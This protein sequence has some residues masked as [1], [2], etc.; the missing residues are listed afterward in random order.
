QPGEGHPHPRWY[1]TFPRVLGHYVRD[2][3]LFT[4]EE[5]VRKVTSQAALRAGFADRGILRG[6]M[7]ADIVVFDDT[8]IRD[9]ATYEDPHHFSEGVST[10]IVNGV[11]V[12]RD[13]VMTGKLPGRAIRGKGWRER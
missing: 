5:A 12:L 6:G 3:K 2:A 1:G 8:S 11:P 10:V 13:G 4:L 7:K 9:R